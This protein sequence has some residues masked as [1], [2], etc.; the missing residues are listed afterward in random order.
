M[1]VCVCLFICFFLSVFVW[2]IVS[3]DQNISYKKKKNPSK[4]LRLVSS[5][6]AEVYLCV[7]S[8]WNIQKVKTK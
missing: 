4:R 6:E 1:W 2:L 5:L 7:G 3:V 8:F